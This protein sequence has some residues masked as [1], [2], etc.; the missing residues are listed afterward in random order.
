MICNLCPNRCNVDRAT[1]LGACLTPADRVAVNRA[2][3]H[4]YEEP[5]ISG[6]RGSGTIF[7]GGCTMRCR[8]CQNIAISR[9]PRGRMCTA[10]DLVDLIKGL[11]GQGVHNI[12]F[13][14]PTHASHLIRAALDRY[15]P[16][17]PVVYNTSGYECV[18]VVQALAPY[19]D[20]WLPDFKYTDRA[21]AD[22]LSGRPD[23]PRFA[24]AAIAEMLRQKP[25][26]YRDGLMRQGVLIRHLV[27]PGHVDASR[28]ALDALRTLGKP[29]LS[30]MAQFTP[31]PLCPE[32][33]RPVKPIEY[34]AVLSYAEKLGFDDIFIQEPESTGTQ[35]IPPFE[36]SNEWNRNP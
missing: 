9:V 21:L 10:A 11:E 36:L 17:V 29:A 27:L 3:P 1:R 25:C 4:F 18:E 8:Y 34:K 26:L 12:N 23:Y 35:Y 13:V 2:A 20:I 16:A 19:V 28:R 22:S 5:P 32:L 24:L 15:R 33:N 30:L 7:F 31:M 14:T 6:Q